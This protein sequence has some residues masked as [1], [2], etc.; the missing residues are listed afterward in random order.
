MKAMTEIFN[1]LSVIED[2]NFTRGSFYAF[3][4]QSACLPVPP[5][6][7]ARSYLAELQWKGQDQA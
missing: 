1:D 2:P 6:W 3:A 7:K 4:F 5:L